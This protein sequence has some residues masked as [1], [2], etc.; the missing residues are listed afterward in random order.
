[1]RRWG[2]ATCGGAV[3]WRPPLPGRACGSFS[4]PTPPAVGRFPGDPRWLGEHA[5]VFLPPHHLRRG[6]SLAS[7]V[8]GEGKR[9]HSSP[10][11]PA[12]GRFPGVPRPLG[13]YAEVFLP[14]IAKPVGRKFLLTPC[15][16]AHRN[17]SLFAIHSSLFSFFRPKPGEGENKGIPTQF[18]GDARELLPA[19]A[20]L[21]HLYAVCGHPESGLFS[22]NPFGTVFNPNGTIHRSPVDFRPSLT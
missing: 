18:S 2:L 11:P 4:S 13:G 16:Q 9:K 15:R 14:H 17:Y 19:R 7:P 10:T 5:K 3:P 8:G 21:S 12:V 6:G 20:I 22:L 1:M